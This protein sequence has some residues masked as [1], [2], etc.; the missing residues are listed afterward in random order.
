[1]MRNFLFLAHERGSWGIPIFSHHFLE[2]PNFP[3][4]EVSKNLDGDIYSESVFLYRR[5]FNTVK[6]KHYGS[7]CDMDEC[8]WQFSCKLA[9]RQL[10]YFSLYNAPFCLGNRKNF[11]L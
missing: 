4:V 2:T 9:I 3:F 6:F 5:S 8:L 10:P 7:N 11:S 1:M